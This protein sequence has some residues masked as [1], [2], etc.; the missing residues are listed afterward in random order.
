MLLYGRKLSPAGQ[1]FKKLLEELFYF[2]GVC[3]KKNP[4]KNIENKQ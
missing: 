4:L 2:D 1:L 3:M